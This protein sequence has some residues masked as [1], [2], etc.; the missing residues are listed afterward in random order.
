MTGFSPVS[1]SEFKVN[2]SAHNI[3]PKSAEK[4]IKNL[5]ILT[6]NPI[7]KGGRVEK[8]CHKLWFIIVKRS[9]KVIQN[10]RVKNY[11]VRSCN[12][13]ENLIKNLGIVTIRLDQLILG[14]FFQFLGP[15]KT[16]DSIVLFQSSLKI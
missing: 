13:A 3:K 15:V 16:S 7:V 6:K 8:C 12:R 2:F 14:S 1:K 11:T 9:A 5:G 4:L 10:K